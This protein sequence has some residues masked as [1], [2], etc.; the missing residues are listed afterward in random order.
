M[1]ITSGKIASAQKIVLYG[2]EG[3]GKSTFASQFFAPL[4]IDTEGSTKHLDV[5]RLPTPQSWTMLREEINWVI[6]NPQEARCATLV[7]D[8][9]DWAEALCIR[10]LCAD[11]S[12]KG[13]ESPGYGKG[14]TFL[15]EE[16]GRL[17]NDLSRLTEN[18]VNVLLT[19]HAAIRKFELPDEMGAYDR[20]ELKLEKKTASLVKEWADM[21]L[22]ANYKTMVVNVDGQGAAKG[23]NKAQ[24]GQR[25]MYTSHMP[26]WDAKNRCGLAE[27]VPFSYESIRH[28]IP[29]GGE[30]QAMAVE[31]EAE[32][33]ERLER[34]A[35]RYETQ[36]T[37]SRSIPPIADMPLMQ[38]AKNAEGEAIEANS[39]RPDGIPDAL[40]QLMQANGVKEQEIRMAV[41]KRG[42]FPFDTP[43][44]VYG[45]DFISG[46]LIGAW[47]QIY[48]FIQQNKQ[49]MP[50]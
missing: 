25:V 24:G 23:K 21:L 13:I 17:L 2:P 44:H 16:F 18:G 31:T 26:S 7:I 46:V 19:A 45:E 47:P 30:S 15:E 10:Q 28:A 49:D 9:V 20:W 12:W 33:T 43:I 22:F 50:F 37:E 40:W 48:S 38:L 6:K 3:I 29:G 34:A 4:F 32:K 42:Y 27:E 35:R 8:T 11:N 41:S 36:E 5:R 39:E 14:Y 1:E